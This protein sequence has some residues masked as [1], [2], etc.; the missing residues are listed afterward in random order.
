MD[1]PKATRSLPLSVLTSLTS[2][3][4]LRAYRI[5]DDCAPNSDPGSKVRRRFLISA[6]RAK[7]ALAIFDRLDESPDQLGFLHPSISLRVVAHVFA[8]QTKRVQLVEPEVIAVE[9]IIRGVIGV[10][11]QVPVILHEHERCVVLG[12]ENRSRFDNV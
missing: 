8:G 9:V 1:T 5:D 2:R 4:D 10:P 11:A 3:N 7:E 12:V 6:R